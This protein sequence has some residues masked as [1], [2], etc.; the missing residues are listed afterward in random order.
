M[1]MGL[2]RVAAAPCFFDAAD[3]DPLPAHSAPLNR[4]GPTSSAAAR[5]RTKSCL[6][7]MMLLARRQPRPPVAYYDLLD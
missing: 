5:I 6:L 2:D 1:A 4:N 7:L 3:A